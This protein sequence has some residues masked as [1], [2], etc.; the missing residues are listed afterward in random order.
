M[1]EKHLS[2]CH[3]PMVI[4]MKTYHLISSSVPL[5]IKELN[6]MKLLVSWLN[7]SRVSDPISYLMNMLKNWWHFAKNMILLP[8]L[9]RSRQVSDVPVKCS[10]LSIMESNQTLLP[11]VKEYLLL[12][13]SRL[14]LEEVI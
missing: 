8:F 13:L 5:R 3:F 7:H 6:L 1:K 2:R 12:Y 14:L 9:T 11:A 4:R 10:P